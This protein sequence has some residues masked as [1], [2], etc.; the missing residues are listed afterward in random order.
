MARRRA[1][2]PQGHLAIEIAT[3]AALAVPLPGRKIGD[4]LRRSKL[5]RRV[6]EMLH[7]PN[8]ASHSMLALPYFG[9]FSLS[10]LSVQPAIGRKKNHQSS[11][12]P[13]AP[14]RN[15]LPPASFP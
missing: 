5:L 3:Y 10:T 8:R 14:A 11:R 13:E 7:E 6:S 15:S 12:I 2:T 4:S 9:V 1:D